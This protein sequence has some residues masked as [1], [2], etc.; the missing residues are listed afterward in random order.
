MTGLVSIL[1][2]CSFPAFFRPAV[3]DRWRWVGTCRR[4]LAIGAECLHHGGGRNINDLYVT[5]TKVGLKYL[6]L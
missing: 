3:A 2:I 1:L 6:A 4:F 5:I